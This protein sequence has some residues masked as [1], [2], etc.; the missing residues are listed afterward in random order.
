M[1][2]HSEMNGQ[3]GYT[4]GN[5]IKLDLNSHLTIF[6]CGWNKDIKEYLYDFRVSNS[7]LN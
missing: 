2:S 6:N 5:R 3:Q 1:D 7:D 4:C